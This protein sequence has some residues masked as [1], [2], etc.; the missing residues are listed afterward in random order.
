MGFLESMS[1]LLTTCLFARG[2][3]D[4]TLKGDLSSPAVSHYQLA[5]GRWLETA[6]LLELPKLYWLQAI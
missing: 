6:Q 5:K 4:N 1:C 2:T 3:Q